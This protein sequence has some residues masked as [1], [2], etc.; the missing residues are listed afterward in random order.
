MKG[1]GIV[2]DKEVLL[3]VVDRL[4][5]ELEHLEDTIDSVKSEDIIVIDKNI[6]P[7]MVNLI[8]IGLILLMDDCEVAAQ[9]ERTKQEADQWLERISREAEKWREAALS[10]YQDTERIKEALHFA[11]PQGTC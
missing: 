1:G 9:D 8:N 3:G 4:I 6:P 5:N 10:Q 2:A 11:I 7:L